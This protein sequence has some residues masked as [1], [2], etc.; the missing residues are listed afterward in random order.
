MISIIQLM[1]LHDLTNFILDKFIFTFKQNNIKVNDPQFR[2]I[3]KILYL[4]CQCR[5]IFQELS[6]YSKGDENQ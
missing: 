1:S 4:M 2:S 6:M 3:S 5:N